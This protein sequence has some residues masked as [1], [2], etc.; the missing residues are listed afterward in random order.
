MRGLIMVVKQRRSNLLLTSALVGGVF[1]RLGDTALA[2][3]PTYQFDIPAEPLSQAL[4]D[5][6]QAASQQIIYSETLV[7]GRKAPGLHGSYTAAEALN[8]LLAGTDLTVDIN[9]SGVL[10]IEARSVRNNQQGEVASYGARS[11]QR[12]SYQAVTQDNTSAAAAPPPVG[13]APAQPAEAV[14]EPNALETVVV[15]GS[16]SRRTLLDASV[17]I[18]SISN[19]DLEQKAPRNTADVLEMVPGIYVEGTAGPVS[20]NYSVRG[21]PGGGQAFIR[22][23]EDGMP[24][25]YGGLNDD[26]VFQNDLS[27]DHVEALEGGS[28]GVLTPNAAGASIN[29][30]SRKLNFDEGN[31]LAQVMGTTYGERR[32]DTWYSAPLAE[33]LAFAVSGYYDSNPGTRDSSF[34]YDTW[35]I[36]FQLEKKFEN[37]ASI[38]LTYKR[39][40]E[41]DPYYADQPYAYNNGRISSVPGLDSQF[42]NVVGPSFGNITVPDSCVNECFRTFSAQQGIHAN[43]ALYRIDLNVP[44]T[45][46][47]SGF[48]RVRYTATDW[49]FNGVFSGSGTGNSGLAS[50]VTYLTPGTAA[51]SP[52]ASLLAAG[53]AAFPGTTQFGIRNT[54]TGQIIPSSDVAA[55]NALNG[56]GLLQQTVLNRQLLKQRDW[57]SDFGVKYDV[58]AGDWTNSLTVG[59]MVYSTHQDNDQSGVAP[60]LNDVVNQSNIYDVVALNNSGGV[61]GSLTN[62]GLVSY[63]DW[64]AGISYYNENSYSG[65]FNNEFTWEKKLHVDF[66]LRFEHEEESAAA[67]N[68]TSMPIPPGIQGVNQTN[69]NA[70]N[71]TFNYSSAHETPTNYT[72]G[73]NY[74]VSPN[75]SVYTRYERGY[76]TQGD[77][78]HATALILY[79]AGITFG[80]Y[81]LIGTLR[82]FRTLF[83]NQSFGGGVDPANPNLDLGFFGN[84]TTNGVDLDATYRPQFEPLRAFSLHAQATYQSSTFNNASV[85]DI[86]ING[87]NI[88]AQA[89]AFYNGKTPHNTPNLMYTITPQYDLPAHYGQ[90]YLRYMH[91]GRIFADNGDQVELP[92]YGVLGIGAIGNITDKLK[93]N[94]SVDNITNALGLTEGNPRQGF[95]QSIVNGYFY[96]RGIV[97]PTALVSLTYKF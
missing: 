3:A 20:N 63:G 88:S 2:A 65:Y 51:N 39:W 90:V 87:E 4:T 83:D 46:S 28:S 82:G 33:G 36:K 15:T 35:H 76:Q 45:D 79:E 64:G 60:V 24:P 75:L 84:S 93:L 97:G 14:T 38:K 72:V 13:P 31:G 32:A 12:A 53:L 62:N 95:T 17:A 1:L 41:H 11:L 52:I 91:I 8:T 67:G 49:D 19:E 61:L 94:V 70:F 6:S 74:T 26:E 37:G 56:N 55:L 80:D 21:L 9:P 10:M 44:I 69:P 22:L 30:I 29:F 77:N 50:A 89:D 96:G 7:K 5:F 71:G 85:G 78:P 16:T 18:T 40:D 43:G 59:A 34:R 23:I 66:G 58:D 25:V 47:I 27:I 57:G 54:A 48:A 42:G 92:A 68:S 81:G 86:N 73:I